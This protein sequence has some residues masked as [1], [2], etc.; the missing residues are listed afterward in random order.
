MALCGVIIV[1]DVISIWLNIRRYPLAW[2]M[3]SLNQWKCD[4]LVFIEADININGGGICCRYYS[5]IRSDIL[6]WWLY[7]SIWLS[8]SRI[9]LWSDIQSVILFR[10]SDISSWL[11]WNMACHYNDLKL[12][13]AADGSTNDVAW[14]SWRGVPVDVANDSQYREAP[15]YGNLFCRLAKLAI[16]ENHRKSA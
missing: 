14:Y 15:Y 7:S 5:D 4:R 16:R 10:L 13:S 11:F 12:T 1:N 9:N 8:V 3:K 6:P 2:Q